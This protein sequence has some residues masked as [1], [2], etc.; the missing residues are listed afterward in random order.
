ME[1]GFRTALG[2]SACA[3]TT[4]R[5]PCLSWPGLG[6]ACQGV[7]T[8]RIAAQFYSWYKEYYY[9]FTPG[10]VPPGSRCVYA[11]V[12][13]HYIYIY[14]YTAV[15]EMPRVDVGPRVISPESKAPASGA[16]TLVEP[17]FLTPSC[18]TSRQ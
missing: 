11:A 15:E 14:I 13:I 17:S 9:S 2:T 18:A 10:E 16:G 7:Y 12:L 6:S 8:C 3:G 4:S 5:S 1:E